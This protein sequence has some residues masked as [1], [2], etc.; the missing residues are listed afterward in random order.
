MSRTCLV[1][2]DPSHKEDA[3]VNVDAKEG[4]IEDEEI[5]INED[6]FA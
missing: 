4:E 6:D 1:D 2:Q 5:E 3:A